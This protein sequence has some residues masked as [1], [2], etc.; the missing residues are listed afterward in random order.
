MIHLLLSLHYQATIKLLSLYYN[1][2]INL[3]SR[4]NRATIAVRLVFRGNVKNA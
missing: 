3:L 4:Y 1:Y 2:T